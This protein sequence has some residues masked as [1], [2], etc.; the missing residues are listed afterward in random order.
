[1]DSSFSFS[2]LWNDKGIIYKPEKALN[3]LYSKIISLV[4]RKINLPKEGEEFTP[5]DV[6]RSVHFAIKKVLLDLSMDNEILEKIRSA[7]IRLSGLG[8]PVNVV[9]AALVKWYIEAAAVLY[10]HQADRRRASRRWI[11]GYRHNHPVANLGFMVIL[12]VLEDWVHPKHPKLQAAS[13]ISKAAISVLY[14]AYTIVPHIE[15]F[16]FNHLARMPISQ[17][18]ELFLKV[19]VSVSGNVYN[20]DVVMTA[21][22]AFE[23]GVTHE[24]VRISRGGK[25]LLVKVYTQENWRSIPDWH[26][27]CKLPGSPWNNYIRNIEQ[28]TFSTDPNPLP[29]TEIKYNLPTKAMILARKLK[30]K[31][32]ATHF[33][34]QLSEEQKTLQYLWLAQESG[35]SYAEDCPDDSTAESFTDVGDEY[36]YHT[37]AIQ[38][39]RADP[40]GY[41]T[42]PFMST[43]VQAVHSHSDPAE[44]DPDFL[45]MTF[46]QNL[47]GAFG[48]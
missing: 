4:L 38:K 10:T 24:D 1:M 13:L 18:R 12:R 6:L 33:L 15:T 21:P 20:D 30:E 36:L 26:P 19:F 22:P 16:A 14:A 3:E 7:H 25:R 5:Q 40:S 23:Y 47:G 42:L 48:W 29:C 43:A 41:L 8:T 11:G 45:I 9:D 17:S 35:L 44:P 2:P 32:S 31:Y 27:Y 37:P 46:K 34:S 39:P 28:P